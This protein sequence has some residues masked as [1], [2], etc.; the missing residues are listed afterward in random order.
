MF[1]KDSFKKEITSKE[2]AKAAYSYFSHNLTSFRSQLASSGMS[3][4]DVEE[5][6]RQCWLNL[7]ESSQR[8][9]FTNGHMERMEEMYKG[10]PKVLPKSEDK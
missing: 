9:G 4:E 6:I 2:E 8:V 10:K 5:T 3:Y 7:I 1:D